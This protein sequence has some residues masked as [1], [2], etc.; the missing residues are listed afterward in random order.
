[1]FIK[2][3]CTRFYNFSERDYNEMSMLCFL[4]YFKLIAEIRRQENGE[5]LSHKELV[6]KKIK[7]VEK[8]M[9]KISKN[10]L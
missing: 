2:A 5:K 9:K 4:N 8:E 7:L 10:K 3:M 1:M 6:D